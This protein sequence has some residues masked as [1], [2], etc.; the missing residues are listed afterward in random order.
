MAFG[1]QQVKLSVGSGEMLLHCHLPSAKMKI[2][3]G[4]G[5][6]MA[7]KN[8]AFDF[9]KSNYCLQFVKLHPLQ[10]LKTR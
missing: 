4:C 5:T 2:P 7:E 6:K 3:V 9:T 1:L 8:T 10:I